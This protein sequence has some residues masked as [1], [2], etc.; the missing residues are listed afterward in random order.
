MEGNQE[1]ICFIV[2]TNILMSALLKDDSQ[3]A[4]LIK[5][6]LFHLYYPEDGLTELEYY[7]EYIISKR[8]KNLQRKS[9]E[10]AITFIF[11]SVNTIPSNFYSEKLKEAYNIMKDIDE[12]DTLFLA[13]ALK[14]KYPIW[15]ND[16]HFQKQGKI[17]VYTTED[18]LKN[19]Y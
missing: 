14:L 4:K 7:K 11:E 5:S 12:K 19:Y 16:K 15:S 3:T 2:D 18:V 13:L 6:D 9:L 10:Y 1:K 17:Q 8:D